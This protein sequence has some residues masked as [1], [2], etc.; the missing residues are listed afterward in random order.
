MI[1]YLIK[2]NIMSLLL[3]FLCGFL[4]FF[5][6]FK[7]EKEIIVIA[8]DQHGTRILN[9]SSDETLKEMEQL[10]F[11]KEFINYYFNF[12]NENMNYKISKGIQFLSSELWKNQE[13]EKYNKFNKIASQEKINH[14]TTLKKV[15]YLEGID[16]YKL[17]LK[18]IFN[19]KGVE[20][21]TKYIVNIKIR[22]IKRSKTNKWGLEIYEMHRVY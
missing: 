3:F 8:V 13:I 5:M 22:S 6:F 20:K 4:I 17:T 2:E 1:R 11:I 15:E 19:K 10:Q 9:D 18:S 12:N 16:I 14:K 21:K 7:K